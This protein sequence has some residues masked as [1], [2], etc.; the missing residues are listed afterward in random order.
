MHE[1]KDKIERMADMLADVVD[2]TRQLQADA[3]EATKALETNTRRLESEAS[4]AV[5][6]LGKAAG[7]LPDEVSRRVREQLDAAV[8]EAAEEMIA[9]WSRANDAADRA[10]RAYSASLNRLCLIGLVI[11][12][13]GGLLGAFATCR[14]IVPTSPT[15]SA[16]AE[17]V[18]ENEST[19]SLRDRLDS[20]PQAPP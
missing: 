7:D 9:H 1:G 15:Q 11:F 18:L 2:A 16:H 6:K 19:H 8:H 10:T 4:I 14:L 20:A 5:R 13:L 17:V 12:V 3:Q